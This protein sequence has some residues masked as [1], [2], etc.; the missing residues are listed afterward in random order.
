MTTQPTATDA[1]ATTLDAAALKQIMA[2]YGQVLNS[3]REAIDSLNVFP[4]P[5]GDTGTNMALTVV[6]VLEHV[7][8]S[9]AADAAATDSATPDLAALCQAISHGSLMGA[10]G[11]SGVIL[12]QILRGLCQSFQAHGRVDAASLANG[13]EAAR[14]AAYEAV[15]EP[16]EGTILTVLSDIAAQ[17]AQCHQ[18]GADLLTMAHSC[19]EAGQ[20]S[21]ART[22]ELLEVLAEAG[23]VDAGGAGLVL[24]WDAVL[25]ELAGIEL[26]PAPEVAGAVAVGQAQS[27]GDHHGHGS[28]DAGET[29]Y[30]VMF[31]LELPAEEA[32]EQ[33]AIG[34]FRQSWAELGDSIVVVGGDG[35]WNCHIHTNQ[36]GESIEAGI[37]VGRPRQIRITDLFEQVDHLE[38]DLQRSLEAELAGEPDDSDA[39]WRNPAADPAARCAVV[40]VAAGSGIV[41]LLGELNVHSVVLG[42]QTMNP[43]TELLLEALEA[44]GSPEVVL[45]PNNKNIIPVAE[46]AAQ[47]SS[48]EVQVLPSVSIPEGVAAMVLYDPSQSAVGN[49]KVMEAEVADLVVGQV[50]EAVRETSVGGQAVALGDY[51]GLSG[52]EIVAVS[53]Q[54]A[55]TVCGL[56]ASMIGSEHTLLMLYVGEP[57]D[58][59]TTQAVQNWLAQQ[60]PQL[61]VELHAG[62]QPLYHYYLG[63]F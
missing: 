22:P 29:R 24:L 46:Q 53:Q 30:E 9:A 40:A 45:L 6:S 63:L 62:N 17:A 47:A 38:S 33:A 11:N 60:H 36:I 14:K 16:R 39:I 25:L 21:L 7:E 12:S 58:P 20:Q 18:Q 32:A 35:L 61:E 31:F 15:L 52:G 8:S 54:L 13:W 1:D 43:S 55:E 10:R 2:A 37:E 48:K 51:I 50:T 56:L 27:A 59:D 28:P 49:C 42:G 23:V 41:K 4:V 34:Q 19:R 5:D 26:P 57:A 44:V 3:H